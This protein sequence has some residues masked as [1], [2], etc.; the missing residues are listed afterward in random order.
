MKLHLR[1]SPWRLASRNKSFP[2]STR[3]TLGVSNSLLSIPVLFTLFL[4]FC[5]PILHVPSAQKAFFVH[6]ELFSASQSNTFSLSS[7]SFLTQLPS[8]HKD[9]EPAAVSRPPHPET[10]F[11]LLF[12]A[13]L[14]TNVFLMRQLLSFPAPLTPF[15]APLTPFPP[16]ERNF[17]A[18]HSAYSKS[19]ASK[20]LEC[21]FP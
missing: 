5:V 16:P 10:V 6:K 2:F 1:R 15:P 11:Q 14:H 4:L 3:R 17:S 20:H 19:A 21:A 13:V 9:A 8:A 12:L 18:G 7:T